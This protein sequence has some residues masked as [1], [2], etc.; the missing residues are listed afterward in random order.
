MR[1][2]SEESYDREIRWERQMAPCRPDA[3]RLFIRRGFLPQEA[4]DLTQETLLRAYRYF[5]RIEVARAACSYVLRVA[6]SMMA[7]YLQKKRRRSEVTGLGGDASEDERDRFERDRLAPL[8]GEGPQDPQDAV[9]QRATQSLIQN[10]LMDISERDRTILVLH[11]FEHRSYAEIGE[12]LNIK[13][14]AVKVAAD[15]ARDRLKQLIV[16]TQAL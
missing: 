16:R 13:A 7:E 5:D 3:Y 4:E 11:Y 9:L 8:F 14:S 15:R 2:E 12:H 1:R 10:A 6:N